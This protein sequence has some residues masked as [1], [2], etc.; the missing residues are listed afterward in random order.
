MK[1]RNKDILI[2]GYSEDYVTTPNGVEMIVSNNNSPLRYKLE[3]AEELL[4]CIY[5]WV[6]SNDAL[7]EESEEQYIIRILNEI[8]HIK[9]DINTFFRDTV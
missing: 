5:Q 4:K 2:E 7:E 8:P 6:L 9:E 3:K 1:K